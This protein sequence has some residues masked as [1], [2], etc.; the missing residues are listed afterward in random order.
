DGAS[1]VLRAKYA[2]S[3][4]PS[5]IGMYAYMSSTWIDTPTF[6]PGPWQLW[7]MSVP[8]RVLGTRWGPLLSMAVLNALWYVLAGW[9]AKRRF[10]VGAG[11]G[12]LLVLAAFSWSLG[13]ASTFTPVPIVAVVIAFAAFV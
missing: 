7:W 2:L 8:I 13:L 12:V 1:T 11:V 10:G 9:L 3:S 6:F 5:L 4:D